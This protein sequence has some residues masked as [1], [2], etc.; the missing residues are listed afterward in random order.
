[1]LSCYLQILIDSHKSVRCRYLSNRP[2]QRGATVSQGGSGGGG[3]GQLSIRDR[4]AF[5]YITIGYMPTC[6]FPKF[7]YIQ[8]GQKIPK[9]RNGSFCSLTTTAVCR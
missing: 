9:F 4:L 5:V 7:I 3:G 8:R 2:L 6:L 1:M